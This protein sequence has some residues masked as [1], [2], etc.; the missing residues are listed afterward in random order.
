MSSLYFSLI[1]K[2]IIL[3]MS[4]DL[5]CFNMKFQKTNTTVYSSILY[6]CDMACKCW[7]QFC[8]VLLIFYYFNMYLIISEDSENVTSDFW[9]G[10]LTFY[11]VCKHQLQTNRWDP[12]V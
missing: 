3:Q 9:F 6:D 12:G 1:M 10:L 11:S 4:H 8:D 7:L 2:L 5:T